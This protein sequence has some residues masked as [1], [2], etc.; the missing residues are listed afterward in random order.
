MIHP[1]SELEALLDEMRISPFDFYLTGS[2]ELGTPTDASDYDFFAQ[3][4]RALKVWLLYHNFLEHSSSYLNDPQITTVFRWGKLVDVQLVSDLRK[5]IR[6]QSIL[7]SNYALIG[8]NKVQARR[9]WKAMYEL[10]EES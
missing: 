6:V 4:T 3:D 1:T 7:K 8:L 10:L 5:K 9:V 2:R